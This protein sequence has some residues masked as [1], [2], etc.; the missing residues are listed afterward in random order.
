MFADSSTLF[1]NPHPVQCVSAGQSV[2][3]AEHHHLSFELFGTELPGGISSLC[4]VKRVGVR[5]R[6]VFPET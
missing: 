6:V 4:E 1:V 5:V 3:K 2:P